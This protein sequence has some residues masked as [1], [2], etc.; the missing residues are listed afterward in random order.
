[1]DEVRALLAS[2]MPRRAGKDNKEGHKHS[3]GEVLQA[4]STVDLTLSTSFQSFTGTGDSSKVRLLLGVGTWDVNAH[5]DFSVTGSGVGA[6][7]GA[8]FVDDSG[9]EESE[10]AIYSPAST[11]RIT[12]GQSWKV[13]VT[14][15]NTPIEL[16]AKK[17][18]AGGTATALTAH[19]TL[20]AT[21]ATAGRGGSSASGAGV[22]DHGGLTGLGDDDHTQY[23]LESAD[24]SHQS[25]GLE[26]GQIDHGAAAVA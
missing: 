25:T 5:C 8:L 4:E 7:L 3:G 19:T 2:W 20:V 23:R 12:A 21:R 18:V 26:G 13:T 9:T 16:K 22:T 17:T 6:C 15:D 11:G 1:M 10:E 14:A 24:H